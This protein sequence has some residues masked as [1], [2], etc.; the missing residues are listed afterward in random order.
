MDRFASASVGRTSHAENN[1][2]GTNN[3]LCTLREGGFLKM[4]AHINPVHPNHQNC[5]VI[6]ELCQDSAW[7]KK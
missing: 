1:G 6:H 3:R 2:R 7:C 4:T 5:S